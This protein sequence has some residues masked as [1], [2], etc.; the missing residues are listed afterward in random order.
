MGTVGLERVEKVSV[1]SWL[2]GAGFLRL[3]PLGFPS[4]Q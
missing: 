2:D 3:L 1:M 4:L